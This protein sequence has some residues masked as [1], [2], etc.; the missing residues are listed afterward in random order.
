M[1][2]HL[3]LWSMVLSNLL[4]PYYIFGA[5]LRMFLVS[6]RPG[7]VALLS[8]LVTIMIDD[9]LHVFGGAFSLS[10]R[11]TDVTTR[12]LEFDGEPQVRMTIL[13]ATGLGVLVGTLLFPFL[14]ARLGVASTD[15]LRKRIGAQQTHAEATS[16]T[17]RDAAPEAPDA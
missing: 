6:A 16:K 17:A 7:R 3:K 14:L 1:M 10:A 15:A 2:F 4:V 13:V 5:L 9:A 11:L 8:A 12:W